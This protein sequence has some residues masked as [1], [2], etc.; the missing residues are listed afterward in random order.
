MYNML[1]WQCANVLILI[2]SQCPFAH[3]HISTLANYFL[4]FE[5][6]ES[7]CYHGDTVFVAILEREFVFH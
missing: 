3:W 5:M 6:A 2:N 7:R 4:M 1:I